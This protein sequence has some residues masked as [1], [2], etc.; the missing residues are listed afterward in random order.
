[1]IMGPY[2]SAGAL[3]L[4]P[5]PQSTTGFFNKMNQWNVLCLK[6]TN[7]SIVYKHSEKKSTIKCKQIQSNNV[8]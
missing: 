1:V 3:P 5:C 2:A 8:F 7:E 6:N 4:G